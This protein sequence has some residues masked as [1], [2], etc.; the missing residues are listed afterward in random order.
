MF[1]RNGPTVESQCDES[2]LA[3]LG[4]SVNDL[5][6][7]REGSFFYQRDEQALYLKTG[8]CNSIYELGVPGIVLPSRRRTTW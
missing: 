5:S 7:M 8:S 6:N 1:S 2:S 4:R 3:P